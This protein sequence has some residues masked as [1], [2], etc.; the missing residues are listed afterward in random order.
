MTP[1][2]RSPVRFLLLS[3]VS[4]S[5]FLVLISLFHF[6]LSSQAGQ[7]VSDEEEAAPCS[8]LTT[9]FLHD[10]NKTLSFPIKPW[11]A[12]LFLFSPPLFSSLLFFPG[13]DPLSL[14]LS[15]RRLLWNGCHA[16][17]SSSVNFTSSK[18]SPSSFLFC[19]SAVLVL[20]VSSSSSSLFFSNRFQHCACRSESTSH[21]VVVSAL[22]SGSV[23]PSSSTLSLP[24]FRS[25]FSFGQN[26]IHPDS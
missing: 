26:P 11:F 16:H 14:F 13:V 22:A 18:R 24:L 3:L 12:S 6:L 21:L 8:S 20:T 25:S 15:Q 1:A 19:F 5:H 23:H 10:F 9:A 2:I 7:F 17:S 4:S